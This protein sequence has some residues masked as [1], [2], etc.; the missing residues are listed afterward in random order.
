MHVYFALY[1][2]ALDIVNDYG[3]FEFKNIYKMNVELIPSLFIPF[4]P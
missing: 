3:H 2:L 1:Q 4:R